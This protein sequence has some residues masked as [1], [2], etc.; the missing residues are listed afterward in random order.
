MQSSSDVAD[1]Q[2]PQIAKLLSTIVAIITFVTIGVCLLSVP[3]FLFTHS[4]HET[5]HGLACV[6]QGGTVPDWS[7]PLKPSGSMDCKPTINVLTTL[8]GAI[9]QLSVWAL[10]TFAF[11]WWASTWTAVKRVQLG[12]I[13]LWIAWSLWNVYQPISW[14]NHLTPTDGTKWDAA[15]FIL[16]SHIAPSTIVTGSWVMF[17]L[18]LGIAV[19]C[20]F[21]LWRPSWST[22]KEHALESPSKNERPP[23][24]QP[25]HRRRCHGLPFRVRPDVGFYPT[26]PVSGE[27]RRGIVFV[28]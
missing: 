25:R 11:M 3:A 19:T 27:G 18:L 17:A 26:D 4:I 28:N 22:I 21:T 12:S 14:M 7:A 8:G 20:A 13:I 24:P 1:L 10:A 9:L 5:G 15:P 2:K 16:L 23:L 6:A